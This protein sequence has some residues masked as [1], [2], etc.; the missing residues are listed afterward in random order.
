MTNNI[1]EG[2]CVRLRAVEPD[3]WQHFAAWDLDSETARADDQVYFPRSSV[4][5]RR[6]TEAEAL[7]APD[8]DTFRWVIETLDGT[9][10]GTINSH[11]CERRNG[12]FSYGIAVRREHQRKGYAS[13]AIRLVLSYFFDELRYQKV[14]AHVYSFNEPS[15]HLHERLGFQR[16]GCLR[17]M[18]YTN[19]QFFD[20][21]MFG[22]TAEEFAAL[23]WQENIKQT[24]VS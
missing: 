15:L 8:N 2:T 6:W 5:T 7:R 17:R 22:L 11:T 19:G 10:A 9:F 14:V 20:Q 24:S 4:G 3:D 12:T 18:I 23:H 16:E 13:E 21:V 1:W